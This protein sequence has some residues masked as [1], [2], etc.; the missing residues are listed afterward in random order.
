[1]GKRVKSLL[2]EE[3]HESALD[4]NVHV[5]DGSVQL[6]GFVD[7]LSEKITAES[8]AARVPGVK[9]VVNSITIGTEGHITDKHIEK[10]LEAKL[11]SGRYGDLDKISID[12]RDSSAFL[13]GTTP[14]YAQSKQAE[15][16]AAATMGV[17]NVV[18]NLH[19]EDE[20]LYDDTTLTGWAVQALSTANLS[21]QDIDV[22]IR[23]GEITLSGWVRNREEAV[24]AEGLVSEV[25]GIRKVHNRLGIR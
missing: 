7:V 16:I 22:D 5:R 20:G 4:I 19:V 17:V 1:M 13:M 15:G 2:E 14:N 10:E 18:S 11:H 25:E 24:L 8:I 9:R 6:A 12:V 23:N 3:M 21:L